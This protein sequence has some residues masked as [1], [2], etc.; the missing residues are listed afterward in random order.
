MYPTFPAELG[1]G[2]G[3]SLVEPVCR[4]GLP[5]EAGIKRELRARGG[6][7]RGKATWGWRARATGISVWPESLSTEGRQILL[8]RMSITSLCLK[9]SMLGT[10]LL[11]Q[12]RRIHL[13]VQGTQVRS[14]NSG[15]LGPCATATQA[16]SP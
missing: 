16:C 8:A 7:A 13:P 5:P 1:P 11:V 14:P 2:T 6:R 12:W 3:V 9:S 4:W 10:S 15:Q